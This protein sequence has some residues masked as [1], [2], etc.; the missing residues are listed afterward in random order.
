M[1]DVTPSSAEPYDGP[2][3][4]W[5][6]SRRSKGGKYLVE[7]DA[8]DGNGCCQC[9]DFAIHFEPLLKRGFTAQQALDG[10]LVYW[11]PRGEGPGGT[12]SGAS[13]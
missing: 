6:P 10:E 13:T 12:R 11:D 7:L 5:V 1:P 4:Y 9:K 3:R 2:L 8:Y